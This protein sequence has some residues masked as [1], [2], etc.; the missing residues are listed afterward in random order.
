MCPYFGT[1]WPAGRILAQY[2]SENPLPT[3]SEILEVGCGLAVPSLYLAR[4]GLRVAATDLHPDVPLFLERNRKLNQLEQPKFLSLDWRS[5]ESAGGA[6]K[7]WDLVIASDVL[8]DKTQPESLLQFLCRTVAPGGRAIIAD[9]GRTYVE[10]FFDSAAQ[11]GFRV[12]T[13]GLFGVLIGELTRD[14]LS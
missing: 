5:V 7:T 8:Y 1:L 2:L 9:P 12:K 10:G 13:E 11:R 3:E 4:R 14:M 6:S